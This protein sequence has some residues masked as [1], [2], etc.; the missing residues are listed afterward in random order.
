MGLLSNKKKGALRRGVMKMTPIASQELSR[1]ATPMRAS[2]PVSKSRICSDPL[3]LVKSPNGLLDLE[4]V[5]TVTIPTKIR[6]EEIKFAV[7]AHPTLS[8][9]IDKL[10]KSAKT[11]SDLPFRT[12]FKNAIFRN[13]HLGLEKPL[14]ELQNELY[15]EE[16]SFHYLQRGKI[17]GFSRAKAPDN[18]NRLLPDC[19]S[20]FFLFY[21]NFT[22]ILQAIAELYL[23]D[24]QHEKAFASMLMLISNVCC[25]WKLFYTT[26]QVHFSRSKFFSNNETKLKT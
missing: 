26:I 13:W 16:H 17:R 2:T 23:I 3:T 8:E 1:T 15:T 22:A 21:R 18:F 7:D 25:S 11:G 10:F 12:A 14:A 6:D 4:S 5:Q 24:R 9:V 19:D 20:F